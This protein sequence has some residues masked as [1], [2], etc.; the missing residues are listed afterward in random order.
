[1]LT[2]TEAWDEAV[3]AA[4]VAGATLLGADLKAGLFTNNITPGKSNV[5]ADFTEPTYGSYVRQSVIM[6]AAVR[7]PLNGIASIGAGLTWQETGALT[8]VIV[9]G[10][11]YTFGA[12]PALLGA[13]LFP[14]PIPLNDLL[15]AF[16]TILEY[17]ESNGNQGI[18]TIVQ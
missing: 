16:V 7:D 5:I 14:A 1:M 13:E 8:P 9:Y 18:T 6:G 11:F 12:G 17:I 4:L 15:D 2:A 10:I 3:V